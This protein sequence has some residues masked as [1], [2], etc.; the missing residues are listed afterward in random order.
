M[1]TASHE[2]L[3][4][5]DADGPRDERSLRVVFGKLAEENHRDLLEQVLRFLEVRHDGVD[6][7]GDDGLGLGPAAGEL[8]MVV[9]TGRALTSSLPPAAN[10]YMKYFG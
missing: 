2:D 8:F 4:L 6:I 10:R 3:V 1:V 5:G 9:H 7:A